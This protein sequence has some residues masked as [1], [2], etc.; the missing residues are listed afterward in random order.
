MPRSTDNKSDRNMICQGEHEIMM[1]LE[2]GGTDS[3]VELEHT[4]IG[5]ALG[6]KGADNLPVS[7]EDWQR[8]VGNDRA[9]RVLPAPPSWAEDGA[10]AIMAHLLARWP[11]DAPGLDEGYVPFEGLEP[12]STST[13]GSKLNQ[14]NGKPSAPLPKHEDRP[15][16]GDAH[17]RGIRILIER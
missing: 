2:G 8:Y 10:E 9:S 3:T 4:P 1:M 14:E 13:A 15:Y 16:G 11:A 12:A 7:L 5:K 6:K 17:S